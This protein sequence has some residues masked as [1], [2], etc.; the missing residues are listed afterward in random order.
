[1]WIERGKKKVG[2]GKM[3]MGGSPPIPIMR[4]DFL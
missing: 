3:E 2:S 1:M 4:I